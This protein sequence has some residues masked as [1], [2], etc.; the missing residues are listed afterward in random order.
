MAK[1][2]IF[3]KPFALLKGIS[4]ST[5]SSQTPPLNEATAESGSKQPV[6]SATSTYKADTDSKMQTMIG[7][8]A[9]AIGE[10]TK[11]TGTIYSQTFDKGAIK[12]SFGSAEFK[13]AAQSS[14]SDPTY[15]A[16]DSYAAAS[17]AD[18]FLTRTVVSSTGG[19]ASGQ[20]YS[21]ES[22]RTVYLAIDIEK[23]DLPKGPIT[24]SQTIDKYT[25][26]KIGVVDGNVA[27]VKIDAKA[28][29]DHTYVA[30]DA[31]ALS[32]EDSLSTISATVVTEVA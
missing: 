29:A 9:T 31:S 25:P 6:Q 1:P 27:A 17:G 10:N 32:M 21:G 26:Q 12:I 11:A 20:S 8:E 7:G 4:S 18:L 5:S 22:S 30:T 14:E 19:K 16:A 15:A 28:E 3:S 2:T 23:F 13:A 24:I